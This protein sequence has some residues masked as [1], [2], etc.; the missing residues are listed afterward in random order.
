MVTDGGCM[1]G[2]KPAQ[3]ARNAAANNAIASGAR[4]KTLLI[5]FIIVFPL[6][7]RLES[8]WT[9]VQR[10][11]RVPAYSN[12]ACDHRYGLIRHRIPPRRTFHVRTN[13]QLPLLRP[14]DG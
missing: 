6:M 1:P 2:G 14:R 7:A 11:S 9:Q 5:A 4:E 3:P 8:G 12:F 10:I 13:S